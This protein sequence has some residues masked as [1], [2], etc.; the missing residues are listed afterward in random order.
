MKVRQSFTVQYTV[1]LFIISG[2]LYDK[3]K[4][5][6]FMLIENKSVDIDNVSRKK[7]KCGGNKM[8]VILKWAKEWKRVKK[9]IPLRQ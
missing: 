3:K 2:F 8:G 9:A 5:K 6:H 4:K 7:E 1:H